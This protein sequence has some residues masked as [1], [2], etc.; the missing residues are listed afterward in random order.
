MRLKTNGPVTLSDVAA[1]AGVSIKTVSRVVN[2]EANVSSATRERV[3]AV[4]SDLDYRPNIFARS[5]AGSRSYLLSLL[6][7]NP[8]AS[9]VHDLQLGALRQCRAVGYHLIVEEMDSGAADFEQ[10]VARLLQGSLTDGL[11][12]TPPLSDNAL[13]LAALAARGLPCVRI[14]PYTAGEVGTAILI[15]DAAAAAELTTHLLDLGHRR[16]GFIEGPSGHGATRLR[17]DGFASA[18]RARGLAPEPDLVVTGDFTSRSG[19]E[20]G[21]RLLARPDRPTAIF[22]SNDDMALGAMLTASRLGLH[23]PEDLSVAGF[24][25]SRTALLT[26]PQLTTVRQ[27]VTDMSAAA[28][29]VLISR[30]PMPRRIMFDLEVVV[31]GSTGVARG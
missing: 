29:R 13:L 11:I 10:Q 6:F 8:N 5:L 28:A 7:D 26:W 31:R 16:I 4:L 12:L 27:P 17:Y 3:E 22:A 20:A 2:R 19:M 25:D 24:D 30:E 9:Y 1:R 23:I 18:L 15:D 21:E 14:A